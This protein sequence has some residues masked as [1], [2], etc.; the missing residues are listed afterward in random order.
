MTEAAVSFYLI[1]L[2]W[3]I[4][5]ESLFS[6]GK[7]WRGQDFLGNKNDEANTFHEKQIDGPKTFYRKN[8]YDSY[9]VNMKMVT[10]E[11]FLG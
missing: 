10:F 9:S 11:Q 8:M 2:T 5:M 6:R 7:E 3:K 1:A 4:H